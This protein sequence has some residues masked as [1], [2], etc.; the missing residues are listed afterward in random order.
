[1]VVFIFTPLSSW[2]V[3]IALV[4][5]IISQ[6]C[7]CSKKKQ[8]KAKEPLKKT[9]TQKAEESSTG[10]EKT[11]QSVVSVRPPNVPTTAPVASNPPI[12]AEQNFASITLTHSDVKTPAPER[13]KTGQGAVS[14][15]PPNVPKTAPVTSKAPVK[16]GQNVASVRPP[17]PA[18]TSTSSKH[19]KAQGT[20][21]KKSSKA[22]SSPISPKVPDDLVSAIKSHVPSFLQDLA[23]QITGRMDQSSAS[24]MS[25]DSESSSE[26]SS[27]SAS[28]MTER[29]DRSAISVRPSNVKKPG[30]V[31]P[32]QPV[33][34]GQNA[35]SVRPSNVKTTAPMAPKPP[36]KAGQ[37]AVSVRPP[38]VKT[39][40]PVTPKTPVKAGQTAVSVR[41]PN[42]KTPAPVSGKTGQGAVSVKPPNVPTATPVQ[43]PVK[44]DQSEAYRSTTASTVQKSGPSDLSAVFI[45]NTLQ[46]SD[47]NG[48]GREKVNDPNYA[49]LELIDHGIFLGENDTELQT[50]GSQQNQNYAT[51][52]DLDLSIF[53]RGPT[54]SKPK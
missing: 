43:K 5:M 38:N 53:T 21:S 10:S 31:S 15:R 13:G 26:G 8:K 24:A 47:S 20:V 18:T 17:V 44:T 23:S 4:L 50:V 7:G 34:A 12:S 40:A 36:I 54:P 3:A 19:V 29:T 30:P 9:P 52:R 32:K 51:L 45:H 33:K 2:C 22:S 39:A 1:M 49:T 25:S 28:E 14:V 11:G 46:A 6:C 42:V 16:A 41:P 37:N 27:S 35:A 48:S